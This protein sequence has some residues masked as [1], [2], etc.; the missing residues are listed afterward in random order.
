ML[1]TKDSVC[2]LPPRSMPHAIPPQAQVPWD[3]LTSKGLHKTCYQGS[4]GLWQLV[5]GQPPEPVFKDPFSQTCQWAKAAQ[6]LL[7]L[8]LFPSLFHSPKYI[9]VATM[10]PVPLGS[11]FSLDTPICH[12]LFFKY[13]QFSFITVWDGYLACLC[14]TLPTTLAFLWG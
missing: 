6:T 8:L 13:I 10:D 11:P 1:R 5:S 4:N 2:N 9:F 3:P 12:P 7:L 14:I